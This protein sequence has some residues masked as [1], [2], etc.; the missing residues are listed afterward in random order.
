MTNIVKAIFEMVGDKLAEN[1]ESPESRVNLIFTLMDTVS[2][3]ESRSIRLIRVAGWL[4][5]RVLAQGLKGLWFKSLPRH[6]VV[7][8]SFSLTSSSCCSYLHHATEAR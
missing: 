8:V 4:S 6:P 2:K 3:V 1:S 7:V 5:G